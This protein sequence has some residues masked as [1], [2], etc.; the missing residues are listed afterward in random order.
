MLVLSRRVSEKLVLP[1]LG[2]TITVVAL[3][4]GAVRLG[5]QAPPQVTVLREEIRQR[6]GRP[7]R[8]P[9]TRPGKPNVRA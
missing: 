7:R 6:D 2:T 5:I 3:K 8:P 1:E 9:A 4:G